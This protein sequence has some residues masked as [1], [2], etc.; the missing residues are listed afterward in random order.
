MP[1]HRTDP[2]V[3]GGGMTDERF[4]QG[5]RTRREVLG[6]EYVDR[7]FQGGDEFTRSWQHLADPHLSA[8]ADRRNSRGTPSC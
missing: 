4:E 5:L 3:T 8:R 2:N 1:Q 6:A 7:A